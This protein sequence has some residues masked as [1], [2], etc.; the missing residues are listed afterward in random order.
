MSNPL[1]AGLIGCGSLS[2]RG[3]L[4]HLAQADA[5]ERV[6]LVAVCD[7]VEARARET[8]ERYSVH[9]AY[10]ETEALIND[11][12]VEV[13]LVIAPIPYHYPNAMAAIQAGNH[14]YV[15]KAMTTSL[16]EAET[17]LAARDKAGIKLAAAPGYELFPTTGQMRQMVQDGVLGRVCIAYTYTMGFGHEYE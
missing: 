2:Q 14:V 11:P 1:K 3:V 4:P 12:N 16:A 15:Q 6:E 10:T 13:V 17:L 8:A 5:R 7:T 9:K